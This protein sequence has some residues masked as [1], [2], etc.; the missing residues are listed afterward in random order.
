MKKALVTG[1]CGFI[2]SHLTKL[3]LDSGWR[4]HVVDDLSS[5][6]LQN[7][8]N[9]GVKFRVVVP[10]LLGKFIT[11][12]SLMPDEAL[13]V[14][15]DFV[16]NDV[17][18]LLVEM[19][20]DCVFHL[21]AD[22]RVE[23][24][25]KR[26]VETTMNNLQKTVELMTVCKFT[27]VKRLVFASSSA[28]YGDAQV[29]PTKE[30]HAI[31]PNSP[32]GLQKRAVEEF[33]SLYSKLYGLSS[34]AL[35]FSNVYGP[36]SDGSSPYSTAIGA[37]CLALKEGRPLRSDGDGEQSRDLIFVEDVVD[38]IKFCGESPDILDFQIFNVGTG[39]SVKNNQILEKLRSSFQN[40][41]IAQAPA[42]DGDVRNTCLDNTKLISIGWKPKHNFDEGLQK[43]LSWWGL[44]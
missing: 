24:T 12:V 11:S 23:H 37:W 10:V 9:L 4:V 17:K 33:M 34:V 6:D 1:G 29:I 32:Y 35:R 7:L 31:N 18:S 20:Y 42:R 27:K 3:L 13:V 8:T 36:N 39:T 40:L 14:T 5:G 26:P 15:G 2:G 44:N 28:V 19:E 43:T 21:A 38:A 22:A 41:D 30:E 25:V 16:N